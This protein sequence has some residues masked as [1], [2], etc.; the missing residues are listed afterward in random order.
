M[1]FV[2]VLKRGL[3]LSLNLQVVME[4]EEGRRRNGEGR[5]LPYVICRTRRPHV[6]ITL[7]LI[8]C[9][10]L[11]VP[12]RDGASSRTSKQNSFPPISLLWLAL[13]VAM[14]LMNEYLPPNTTGWGITVLEATC[15]QYASS[16]S[17][18]FFNAKG[19]YLAA[20]KTE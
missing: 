8:S 16:L 18:N 14:K 15:R 3:F 20:V 5:L 13:C 17:R 12:N 10:T 9:L 19:A 7:T 2:L 6:Y 11:L 4:T 1:F